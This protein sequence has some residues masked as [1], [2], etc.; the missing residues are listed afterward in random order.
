MLAQY[1]ESLNLENKGLKGTEFLTDISSFLAEQQTQ[2]ASMRESTSVAQ[3]A[4]KDLL[5]MKQKQANVLEA[6]L[7]SE[8]SQVAVRQSRAV[9]IF[10]IFTIIFLPLSFFASVFG[11]NSAEW[12]E[13]GTHFLPLREIFTYMLTLSFGCIVI[14]LLA[15]FSR[16]A[17]RHA[18]RMWHRIGPKLRV[19]DRVGS[20]SSRNA[21]VQSWQWDKGTDLERQA[22]A[23]QQKRDEVRLSLLSRSQT[24]GYQDEK[25]EKDMQRRGG[26]VTG[27]WAGRKTL[28]DDHDPFLHKAF[29]G[30]L[31]GH[32]S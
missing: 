27:W 9:L 23:V 15:A 7:A 20:G 8:Q 28:H 5:D 25:F 24:I 31:N 6:R 13:E 19:N 3:S 21:E 12:N 26:S 11:I 29:R 4:Y 1:T 32:A 14:A 2:V 30:G 10:T 18:R 16:S 17:R 22:A